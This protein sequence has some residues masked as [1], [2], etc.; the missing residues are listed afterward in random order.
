M[1]TPTLLQTCAEELF[2]VAQK[3]SPALGGVMQLH[4]RSVK[5]VYEISI[6]AQQPDKELCLVKLSLKAAPID[7]R[8]MSVQVGVVKKEGT[9]GSLSP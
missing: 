5:G 9:T 2:N 7:Q 4:T 3:Y 1:M 6:T 8:D